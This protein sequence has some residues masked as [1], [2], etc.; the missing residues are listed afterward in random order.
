M[1]QVALDYL[2]P[3][4]TLN[5]RHADVAQWQNFDFSSSPYVLP[6][7]DAF[8]NNTSGSL[9]LQG[10]RGTGKTH[11]L[12][13]TIAKAQEQGQSAAYISGIEFFAMDPATPEDWLE[14]YGGFSILAIDEIEMFCQSDVWSQWLFHLHN[15]LMD[16]SCG[17]LMASHHTPRNLPCVL[18]DLQSRLQKADFLRLHSLSDEQMQVQL[19]SRAH[20]LGIHL[21]TEVAKYI[22]L[23][24]PRTMKDLMA[25][26]SQ[27]DSASW[28]RQRK[29]TIPFIKQTLHW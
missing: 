27:L 16:Q 7:L 21:S 17:M 1:S 11:L 19:Q 15:R 20:E 8:V 29:I 14:G 24:S 18:A 6:A 5:I 28:Q 4:L 10:A 9:F 25:M 2:T 23:H 26:L 13:A 22:C 12:Q 3:Q